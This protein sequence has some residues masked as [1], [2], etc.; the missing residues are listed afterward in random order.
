MTHKPTKNILQE[1]ISLRHSLEVGFL[2][3]GE[4]L[5]KIREEKLFEGK[6]ESF[7]D[8]L[9]EL[10]VSKATASKLEAVYEYFILKYR[11][12]SKTIAQIGWSSLYEIQR[13]LPKGIKKKEVE[14]WIDKGKLLTRVDTT[15][16]L[17]TMNAGEHEHDWYELRLRVCRVCHL[18]EKIYDDTST[19]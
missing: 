14:Q 17:D 19:S 9:L 4:Y 15:R 6:Y 13:K 11:F 7:E 16:E 3:L 18:R 10:R 1:C 12:P 8:F 5:K 2:K